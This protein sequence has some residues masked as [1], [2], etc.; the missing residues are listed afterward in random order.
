[1]SQR[2]T[3]VAVIGLGIVLATGSLAFL[4]SAADDGAPLL[5]KRVSPLLADLIVTPYSEFAGARDLGGNERLRFGVMIANVGEGD[6]RLRA[7]RSNLFSEDWS[8]VQQIP[9]AQGGVTERLTPATLV[10]GGDGHDHWHIREVEAHRIEALDG[11]VLGEVV[12][13]GFCFF[14]TDL[15]DDTL[16]GVPVRAVYH[17]KGCGGQ[18]ESRVTMG[19]SVGWGDEYPWHMFEQQIDVT[20]IPDGTY[21]LRAVADP[22]GWFEEK[23]ETNNEY[24]EEFALTRDNNGIPDVRVLRSSNTQ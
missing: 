15:V 16:S 12:K 14:D 18:I 5:A 13:E 11:T 23:D 24:W 6:F 17:S 4:A 8:V 3:L 20:T 2:G 10:F 19:L 21:R 7:R 1:M 9:E 22:Y